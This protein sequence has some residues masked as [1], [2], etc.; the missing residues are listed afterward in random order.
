MRKYAEDPAI[1]VDGVERVLDAAHALAFNC[2][3]NFGVRKVDGRLDGHAWICEG[4]AARFEEGRN[5]ADFATTFLHPEGATCPH[6][7]SR[8]RSTSDGSARTSRPES[9]T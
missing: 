1:G 7:A 5:P 6:V 9:S 8:S 3:R 2:R 4:G